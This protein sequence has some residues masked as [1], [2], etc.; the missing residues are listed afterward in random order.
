MH[1]LILEDHLEAQQWLNKAAEIAFGSSIKV[2]IVDT[3]KRAKTALDQQSY[4]LFLIDLHLPD[5][6]GQDALIYAKHLYPEMD[7][8]IATIYSD[9]VH[10]FPALRAGATGYL[11]K[12]ET[13]EDIANMLANIDGGS[14]PLSS[15][16]A[17][18]MLSHFY[19]P[20]LIEEVHQLTKREHE[21]L[22][23]IIKGMSVKECAILMGISPHTVSSYL[24][25]IYSKLHV[26]SRAE[27][28]HEALRLKI[29]ET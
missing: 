20:E 19:E 3:I 25:E 4:D 29:I 21:T 22:S 28:T 2:T 26:S 10:L 11:L 27:M 1:I 9:D 13:K 23:I 16:I 24:K 6:S 7:C 15:S 18:K 17:Q 5:G 14:P 12:D 8:I